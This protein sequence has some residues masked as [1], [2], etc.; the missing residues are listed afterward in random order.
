MKIFA[1]E[2]HSNLPIHVA[3]PS[4]CHSM[5][6][7]KKTYLVD[8]EFKIGCFVPDVSK[9]DEFIIDE[10]VDVVVAAEIIVDCTLRRTFIRLFI[11]NIFL[12]SLMN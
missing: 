7:A 10:D 8:D 3:N 2:S 11:F 1:G 4:R 9:D 12:L 6:K 5:S